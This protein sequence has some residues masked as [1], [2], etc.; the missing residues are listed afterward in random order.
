MIRSLTTLVYGVVIA[1]LVI[2]VAVFAAVWVIGMS[3][4][5][6]L[7]GEPRISLAMKMMERMSK[8]RKVPPTNIT[9]ITSNSG[10]GNEC[11]SGEDR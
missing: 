5:A 8:A 1:V 3:A 9:H 10:E 6:A 2:I 7:F 4:K 11:V